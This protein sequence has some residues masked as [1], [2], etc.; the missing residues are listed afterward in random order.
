MDNRV[1]S[2]TRDD[3]LGNAIKWCDWNFA[4]CSQYFC[5]SLFFAVDNAGSNL[6]GPLAV[7]AV[8]FATCLIGGFRK[9]RGISGPVNQLS[10]MVVKQVEIKW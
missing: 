7:L 5:V 8:V 1:R 4:P 3:R 10:R 9:T 2:D 6:L